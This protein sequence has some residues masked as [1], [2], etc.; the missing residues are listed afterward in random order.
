MD[1]LIDRLINTVYNDPQVKGSGTAP[2]VYIR[3]G[4]GSQLVG[5]AE[6]A[7]D[8]ECQKRR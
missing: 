1:A 4:T 3:N 5:Y 2:V 8:V 6:L 7:E